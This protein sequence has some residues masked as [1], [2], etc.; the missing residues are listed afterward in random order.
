MKVRL[1]HTGQGLLTCCQW[2]GTR[3]LAPLGTTWLP[4]A[5][6]HQKD[7]PCGA[8]LTARN[9]AVSQNVQSGRCLSTCTNDMQ[10]VGLSVIHKFTSYT[11]GRC[12]TVMSLYTW[13]LCVFIDILKTYTNRHFVHSNVLDRCFYKCS[14]FLSNITPIISDLLKI[15]DSQ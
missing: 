12:V 1:L 6:L 2:G 15:T 5:E 8:T 9:I 11:T 13:T 4:E 10:T 14:F 7:E 3:G